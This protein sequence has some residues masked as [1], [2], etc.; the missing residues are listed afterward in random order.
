M[1]IDEIETAARNSRIAAEKSG[2]KFVV[3]LALYART[4]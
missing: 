1:E 4:T 2:E 3:K